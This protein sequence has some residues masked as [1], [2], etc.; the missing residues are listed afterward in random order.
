MIKDTRLDQSNTPTW[1]KKVRNIAAI[2]A[3][4]TGGL[5]ATIAS[6]GLAAP[7]AITTTLTVIATIS[8]TVAGTASL[9]KE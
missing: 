6:G 3:T 9:T 8:T 1:W 7:A 4:V 2:V 5:A